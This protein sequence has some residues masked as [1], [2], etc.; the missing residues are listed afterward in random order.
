MHLSSISSSL[1]LK[2]APSPIQLPFHFSGIGNK[3]IKSA[4][5]PSIILFIEKLVWRIKLSIFGARGGGL[6]FDALRKVRESEI[7]NLLNK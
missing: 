3:D 6:A 7:S 2:I 4:G 1:P 5:I